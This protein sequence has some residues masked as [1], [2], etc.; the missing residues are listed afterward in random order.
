MIREEVAAAHDYPPLRVL[1][2]DLRANPIGALETRA[3]WDEMHRRYTARQTS[4]LIQS[5]IPTFV[6]D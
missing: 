4:P 1:L 5:P 6:A 2:E 3:W